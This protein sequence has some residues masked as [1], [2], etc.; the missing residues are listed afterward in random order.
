[1]RLSTARPTPP[2]EGAAISNA[3]QTR[4]RR[5]SEHVIAD[6]EAKIAALKHRAA[7][8]KVKRDPAL[9]HVSAALR[10][11]EKA[12]AETGDATTT[13]ALE[14]VRVSLSACLSLNAGAVIPSLGSAPKRAPRLGGSV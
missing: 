6:L 5:T 7:Q 2:P 4:T 12:M 1:P 13:K 8:K 10:S 11:I 9:K 3:M 14:E